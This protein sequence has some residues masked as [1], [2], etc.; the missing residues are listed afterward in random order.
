MSAETNKAL[1][2][3]FWA[4]VWERANLG[5]IETLTTEDF[6]DRTSPQWAQAGRAGLREHVAF[7]QHAFGEWHVTIEELIADER[8]IVV[9]WT[10]HGTHQGTFLGLPP[11]GNRVDVGIVS[12]VRVR[13]GRIAEYHG[14]PD[15]WAVLSQMGA[16]IA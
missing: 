7:L 1:I 12:V 9:I 3:Q 8:S 13:D 11:T 16:R 14:R 6:I 4:D 15:T 5:A 10:L 2:Q